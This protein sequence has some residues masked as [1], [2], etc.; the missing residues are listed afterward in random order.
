MRMGY[1]AL[2]P[3]MP[4]ARRLYQTLTLAQVMTGFAFANADLQHALPGLEDLSIDVGALQRRRDSLLGALRAIGYETSLPEGTFYAMVRS[5]IPD[6]R[7]FTRLLRD[8]RVLVLPGSVVEVPGW[9]RMSLTANDRMVER[10]VEGFRLA[11]AAVG[12]A[13]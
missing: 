13:R 6:D 7:A 4:E 10:G 5:P 11:F 3:G 1:I 8:H 9:F 12:A 2:A